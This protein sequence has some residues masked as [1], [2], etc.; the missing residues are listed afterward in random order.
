M[1]FASLEA[2]VRLSPEDRKAF[3]KASRKKKRAATKDKAVSTPE[4]PC[5]LSLLVTTHRLSEHKTTR[6]P[7]HLIHSAEVHLGTFASIPTTQIPLTLTWTPTQLF[8]TFSR[9]RL[10][11]IK[12][13]LFTPDQRKGKAKVNSTTSKDQQSC[14]AK[15]PRNNIYLPDSCRVREIQYYPPIP[16]SPSQPGTVIIGSMNRIAQRHIEEMPVYR[17]TSSHPDPLPDITSPPIGVFISEEDLGGWISEEG[18]VIEVAKRAGGLQR[19]IEKFDA[20]DD[21]KF[22]KIYSLRTLTLIVIG[23]VELYL[24]VQ[25]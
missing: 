9:N 20:N 7:P 24:G 6:S 3:Q 8:V 16:S 21:C 14:V 19:K 4:A 18:R 13:D 15:V 2:E 11:V 22:P 23:D 17:H 5:K 10:R 12:I 25:T 1:H